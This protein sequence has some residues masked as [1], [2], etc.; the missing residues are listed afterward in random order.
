[1]LRPYG[2]KSL[3]LLTFLPTFWNNARTHVTYVAGGKIPSTIDIA[4]KAGIAKLKN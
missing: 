4:E 2:T 3:V 1:M